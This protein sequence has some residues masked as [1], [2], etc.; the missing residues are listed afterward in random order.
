M[1][2]DIDRARGRKGG[3]EEFADEEEMMMLEEGGGKKKKKSKVK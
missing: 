3:L 1:K 2:E